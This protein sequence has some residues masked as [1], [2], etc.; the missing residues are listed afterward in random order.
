M[1]A[2]LQATMDV[3]TRLDN[4]YL[5]GLPASLTHCC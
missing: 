3:F 1:A 5:V 2:D 4:E